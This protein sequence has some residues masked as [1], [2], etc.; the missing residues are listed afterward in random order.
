MICSIELK[1]MSNC[2]PIDL[3]NE[4]NV[5]LG[6]SKISSKFNC[7]CVFILIVTPKNKDYFQLETLKLEEQTFIEC[8]RN[9]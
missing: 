4:S 9:S 1:S 7:S 6:E 8:L 2:F 5:S 3:F